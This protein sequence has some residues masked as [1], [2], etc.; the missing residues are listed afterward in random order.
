MIFFIVFLLKTS[1]NSA[2]FRGYNQPEAQ[3]WILES[4]PRKIP[5]LNLKVILQRIARWTHF[6]FKFKTKTL[7]D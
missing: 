2:D 7:L 1:K 4:D 3:I 5:H 6:W